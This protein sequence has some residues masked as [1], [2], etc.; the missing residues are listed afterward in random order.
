MREVPQPCAASPI[1]SVSDNSPTDASASHKAR[2]GPKSTS[3]TSRHAS[4]NLVPYLR[5]LAETTRTS[6]RIKQNNATPTACSFDPN[7]ATEM[8]KSFTRLE[9]TSSKAL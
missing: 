1:Y 4:E 8:L 6:G 9:Q 2:V 3:Q 7:G 5:G